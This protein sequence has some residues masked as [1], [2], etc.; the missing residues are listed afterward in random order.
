[1]VLLQN[2]V[3]ALAARAGWRTPQPD[4]DGAYRF[5]LA[6]GL[7]FAMFSPDGRQ[8]IIHAALMSVPDAGAERDELLTLAAQR[9][10]GACRTRASV[11]ALEKAGESLLQ[12]DM[13]GDRL[14]L[15]RMVDLS[16]G[17][18]AVNMTIR[19]F[20]NDLTWW[21]A[22]CNGSA[23]GTSGGAPSFSMSGM[24]FWGR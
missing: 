6:D 3:A 16:S 10:A 20:L 12:H 13:Q 22:A 9:Q 14:I 23:A 18:D 15:Y 8:C 2:A 5:R 21:K 17:Q 7:D 11:V 1:M 24:F 4:G 19:D